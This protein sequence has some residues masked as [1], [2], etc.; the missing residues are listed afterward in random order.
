MW[1]AS[2]K[3]YGS[4][5]ESHTILCQSI[6]L[7]CISL[8][9]FHAT[10][11][12]AW[13][14]SLLVFKQAL[15]SMGI[16]QKKLCLCCRCQTEMPLGL[17]VQL[18]FCHAMSQCCIMV[19]WISVYRQQLWLHY[20]DNMLQVPVATVML[21]WARTPPISKRTPYNAATPSVP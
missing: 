20:Y 3:E 8:L 10:H 19:V 1:F 12:D 15:S 2:C 9:I 6:S 16:S 17:K 21:G 7:N 13:F 4:P 18:S 11:Q 5:P 14:N